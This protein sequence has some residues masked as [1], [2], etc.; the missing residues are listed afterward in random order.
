MKRGRKRVG[1]GRRPSKV[2]GL[3]GVVHAVVWIEEPSLQSRWKVNGVAAVNLTPTP[4][5]RKLSPAFTVNS[6]PMSVQ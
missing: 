6:P 4:V 1:E 5:T 2:G 3:Y